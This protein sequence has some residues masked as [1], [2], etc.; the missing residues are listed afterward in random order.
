SRRSSS[1]AAPSTRSTSALTPSVNATSTAPFA[2][3]A[4][5]PLAGNTSAT[6]QPDLTS[7]SAS[8]PRTK[9]HCPGSA[10]SGSSSSDVYSGRTGKPSYVGESSSRSGSAGKSAGRVLLAKTA[11]TAARHLAI[12]ESVTPGFCTATRLND[13]H[14]SSARRSADSHRRC[15]RAAAARPV[16][17]VGVK[18]VVSTLRA[19][20]AALISTASTVSPRRFIAI[21][22]A[23]VIL[24][25][26]AV[27]VPLPTAIQMRDWARTV[28]PWFPLAFLAAHI[29]LT[30]F[31]FPRSAFT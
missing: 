28:G 3:A 6:R 2:S 12:S 11:A 24:I 30:I 25:A 14:H 17:L 15:E 20:R 29:V 21:L 5:D 22:A 31:P 27:L 7:R 1:A 23:I 18:A 8:P 13:G 9:G 19:L 10:G 26:I 4:E 16:V